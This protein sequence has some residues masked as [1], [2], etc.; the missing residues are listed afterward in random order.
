MSRALVNAVFGGR[1]EELGEGGLVKVSRFGS[2]TFLAVLILPVLM[3]SQICHVRFL[4]HWNEQGQCSAS[5]TPSEVFLSFL[6]ISIVI[7]IIFLL[8]LGGIFALTRA[9][10]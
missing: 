4:L 10:K 2:I 9:A 1:A 8:I 3:T 6:V 7:G 5:D